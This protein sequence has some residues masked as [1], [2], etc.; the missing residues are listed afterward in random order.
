MLKNYIKIAWR[1][2]L[3]HKTHTAI[4]ILGMAVA[5]TC[6][7]MILIAV[8][9]DFSYDSF[10]QYKDRVY[11]LYNFA[12]R[13]AG[14]SKSA[15]M[16][17][18]VATYLAKEDLGIDKV[19]RIRGQGNQVRFQD[20][21]LDLQVTLVDN[22]FFDI[23]SFNTVKGQKS[24][25]LSTTNDVV[26]NEHTATNLFG[27]QN[28]IG[29]PIEVKVGGEWKSL[30]VTAVIADAPHN[31]SFKNQVLARTELDPDWIK[32]KE[33]WNHE[34]HRVFVRLAPHVSQAQVEKQL[35]FF[36]QKYRHP[37]ADALKREGYKADANGEYVGLKLLPLKEYHFSND[38]GAGDTVSKTALY[39]LLLVGA[40]IIAIACF[41][42]I[43]IQISLS[44]TRNKE[45]AVRKYLGAGKQQ[46]WGQLFSENIIQVALALILGLVGT[47]TIIRILAHY[48]ISTFD[49]KL[50]YRPATILSL[51]LVLLLVSFISSGYPF[52][53]IDKQKTVDT[54]KGKSAVIKSGLGRSAMITIQFVIAIILICTTVISY[55]QF[56]YLRTAPL[57][58]TTSSII[59][60]PIKETLK[61]RDISAKLRARL[62]ANPAIVSV[63]AS[64]INLG[65]GE[66]GGISKTQIGFDYED[67]KILTT[68]I[69]A[70]Y[71]F[72]KT[73]SITPLE[74][75]DFSTAYVSDTSNAVIIT[76][77]MAKQLGETSP[78]GLTIYTDSSATNANWHVIGVIPDFHLYSLHEKP[79]ALTISLDKNVPV[80]YILVKVNT[81]N[82]VATMDLVKKTYAELE[83]GVVFKGSYVNENID[84]W[85]KKEKRLSTIFSIA[86]SIAIVLSCMGL[87]G[88][89]LVSI[90]QRV[91]EIGV[92]KVLGA[93]VAGITTMVVKEFVKPVLI[94]LFIAIPIAWWAMNLWLQ[95]FIY[96]I[97]MPWWVYPMAGIAALAVAV[98]T[99]GFQSLK[100]AGAN[101]VDS[102]RNE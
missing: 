36:V 95:D 99:V 97:T 68:Y 59:S 5:F 3:K 32:D 35:Q 40:V 66:D 52:F 8:Y 94:A 7:T 29:K 24:T 55:L 89:A 41:N 11:A 45:L 54:F 64:L 33:E 53:I 101:P 63:S 69:G 10:H 6:S 37:D 88:L 28:P 38:M 81:Q 39:I 83:P 77:S 2:M 90:S 70:D 85:Y 44:F 67:K 65:I 62:A 71:D 76:E 15:T 47:L 57:G 78:V 56:Q 16:S 46:I 26:I 17:Y 31:S 87:F 27:S 20:K 72:L 84:R 73:L 12:N 13:I 43:N 49:L 14:T 1:N 74:G 9:Q 23:F 21:T 60:I 92:R 4:N 42:F 25:P 79:E 91:K 75:R 100:A 98:L 93:T 61:G 48:S 86:A 34:N 19:T 96:R 22:D 102:L 58:Y 50:F 30:T 82:P 51:L 18:P 80:N